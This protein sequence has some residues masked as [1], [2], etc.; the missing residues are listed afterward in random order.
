MCLCGSGRK[1]KRCCLPHLPR[2]VLGVGTRTAIS[3]ENYPGAIVECRA[4]ITQYTIWHKS[5]T[6]PFFRAAPER[7]QALLDLDLR[8]LSELVDTLVRCYAKSQHAPEIPEILERLRAN[9]HHS[10]WQRKI[11][12]FCAVDAYL[13]HDDPNLARVELTKL[14]PIT[15][16]TDSETLQLYLDLFGRQLSFSSMQDLI[17]RILRFSKNEAEQLHYRSLKA[18]QYV[19]IGDN[20]KGQSELD[21]A[22]SRFRASDDTKKMNAYSMDTFASALDLLGA[23]RGES[24]LLDEAIALYREALR[25]DAWTLSGRA[26]IFRQLGEAL[27]HKSSWVQALETYESAAQC[28]PQL[29]LKVFMAECYL[30]LNQIEKAIDA[31]TTVDVS[32]LDEAELT[33]YAFIFAAISVETGDREKLQRAELLLKQQELA[34]PF[35][36]SRRDTLLLSVVEAHR[37]GTS[38]SLIKTTRKAIAGMLARANRY[39][40]LEPN[41][42]GFGI[43]GNAI[44]A[45]LAKAVDQHAAENVDN[46]K[47]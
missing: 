30:Q 15:E 39:L 3:S 42:M 8:S 32:L 38:G 29:I 47:T 20:T 10:R 35:F 7:A 37:A 5:H 1:F 13:F 27:R 23:L 11:T 36:R 18:I 44:L 2:K 34:S 25:L 9:I 14:G 46:K 4:D 24:Q 17:D 45:D 19:E 21:V 22:I 28:A 31:I 41:L 6:E 33:D 26:H 40:L 43:R 16:E 12:Y